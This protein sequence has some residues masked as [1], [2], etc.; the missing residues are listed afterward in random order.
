METGD[1][2]AKDHYE[3]YINDN[4]LPDDILSTIRNQAETIVAT[5]ERIRAIRQQ[6]KAAAKS[7][8]PDTTRWS[9]CCIAPVG[10]QKA[11]QLVQSI[12]SCNLEGFRQASD[13]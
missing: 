11:L 7:C 5:L 1:S 4:Q 8:G 10:G 3:K 12:Q 2:Y 6:R 13:S 9:D